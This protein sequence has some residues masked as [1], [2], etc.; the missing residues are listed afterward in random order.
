MYGVS[1]LLSAA[2]AGFKQGQQRVEEKK[3]RI[4]K[5]EWLEWKSAAD[6]N[7]NAI[8]TLLQK[9]G[10]KAQLLTLMRTRAALFYKG[11]KKGA[12][13]QKQILEDVIKTSPL[14][15]NSDVALAIAGASSLNVSQG[16]IVLK[17]AA[18]VPVALFQTDNGWVS[19]SKV[20]V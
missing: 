16:N 15:V 9:N 20:G 6:A 17:N 4:S 5:Q 2:H 8:E 11:Y 12:A 14:A 3:Q 19:P 13:W 7:A 18:G 1:R 10:N